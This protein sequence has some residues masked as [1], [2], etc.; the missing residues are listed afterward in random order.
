M[1][2]SKDFVHAMKEALKDTSVQDL[3]RSLLQ[4]AI[5]EVASQL[6][7]K[8]DFC[9]KSLSDDMR[10]E[11]DS[12]RQAVAAKDNRI[13]SLENEVE[14]LKNEQDNL[15]QYTRRNS[16][17]ISGLPESDNEDVGQKVLELCRY[18]LQIPVTSS[19]IDR[20]HRVG[21]IGS[22]NPRPVLVKFATYG[23]RSSVF[24][25]KSTLRPGGRNPRTPWTLGTAAS[26]PTNTAPD[27]VQGDE[28]RTG[29]GDARAAAGNGAGGSHDDGEIPANEDEGDYVFIDVTDGAA[30]RQ[31]DMP[32][33][34]WL[35]DPSKV[36][37]TEDLT[38]TRQYV[39]WKARCAK[40]NKR[41]KDCWSNDGQILVKDNAGKVNLIKSP[42]DIIAYDP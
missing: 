24:K 1:G 28:P 37:I 11:M 7:K 19:D 32:H 31:V 20:V 33:L 8:I 2:D 12:L 40:R 10:N 17:W 30:A 26:L 41:I 29:S 5:D 14:I 42:Q 36:F 22:S 35:V 39:L 21:K 38:R 6:Q 9:C 4:P 15:E 3:F 16:L 34:T 25:A 27:I 23:A 18:K 13:K